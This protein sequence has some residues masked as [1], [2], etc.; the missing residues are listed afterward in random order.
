LWCKIS[1]KLMNLNSDLLLGIV[2]IPPEYSRYSSPDA[3]SQI[4]NMFFKN[5]E[6][7]IV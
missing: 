2:Y 4:E 1:S 5:S 3:F 6:L 7:Q